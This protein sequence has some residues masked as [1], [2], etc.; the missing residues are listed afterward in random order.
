LPVVGTDKSVEAPPGVS[1]S[2]RL[3]RRDVAVLRTTLSGLTGLSESSER[4][5]DDIG[6]SQP[7]RRFDDHEAFRRSARQSVRRPPGNSLGFVALS[8]FGPKCPPRSFHGPGRPSWGFPPLQRHRRRDPHDPGLP[9][10]ARSVP[11]V[12]HLLDGFFPPMP[13]RHMTPAAAPGVS[14]F[15]SFRAGRPGR[16]AAPPAARPLRRVPSSRL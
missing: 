3:F 11:E 15:R 7:P 16:I 14:T 13:R 4:R 9:H 1:V 5:R 12:S 10:P 2:P 6:S 8:R